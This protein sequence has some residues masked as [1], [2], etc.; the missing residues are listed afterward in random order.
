[1]QFYYPQILFG[2]F[3]LAIP[4]I[5]HLFQLRRF[6]PEP[7]TN[8][9]LL[10]KLIVSS[11][12]SS[13]LKK[14][15]SLITRLLIISCLV[16]AF[17][18]PF[19][20]NPSQKLQKKQISIFL[21]NS[22]SMSLKGDNTSLFSQAKEE[23]LEA[24]PE[25]ETYNLATHDESYKNLRSEDLK[26][27]I[28][29]IVYSPKP[30]EINSIL[31]KSESLFNSSNNETENE[32]IVLSDFQNFDSDSLNLNTNYN[33]HFVKYN[34]QKRINFSIDTVYLET[35]VDENT[36]KFTVSCSEN[37]SKSIPISLYGD[38]KLLG[39]FSL[40]F[41][42]EQSKTYNFSLQ[43]EEILKGKITIEDDGLS[44]DNE[45]FFSIKKPDPIN[46]LVISDNAAPYLDKIFNKDRFIYQQSILDKLEYEDI[47][48]A[49]LVILNEIKQI[50]SSLRIAIENY[51]ESSRLLCIIPDESIEVSNYNLLF[52]KLNLSSYNQL[53]ENTLK[54]TNIN[55]DHPIFQNVFTESIQN[56]DY[57]SFDS[58]FQS[59]NPEKA[60]AFSNNL[61]L[62]ESRGKIYRFNA[63][64]QDNSNFL[65][66]PLVVIS[67]YNMAIQAQSNQRLFLENGDIFT[68]KLKEELSQDEVLNV[69]KE[70]FSFIP[71]QDIN[72]REIKLN[73][74]DYPNSAGHYA[75]T[76]N[77]QDTL[78]ILA[79]NPSR[80]ES[81][82]E[83]LELSNIKN[84]KTY[85]DFSEYTQS[86][87]ENY[88]IQ[89][90]WKWFIV[91]AL[92][93]MIIEL[94]LLRYIK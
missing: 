84:I 78:N 19:I 20:P 64:I 76:N 1:M 62:L 30:I 41:E 11:R 12:K 71:R 29:D 54:L 25:N 24:L 56:F 35:S 55:F 44:Y 38:N 67:F 17:A 26:S 83:Y 3:A 14:W 22:Y 18:Q 9:V 72:G 32:L 77:K 91:L 16:L 21:D 90:L 61:P 37:I 53:N 63:S 73:F 2:L 4:I 42:N 6:K 69:S 23:L 66:S 43:E 58:Y 10:K 92:I 51:A 87:Y 46:V 81:A 70:D 80:K 86:F 8:V 34:P 7:F 82:L 85:S 59:T 75:V 28:Y 89:S 45:L 50:P 49:D 27:L 52:E 74:K 36:L 48:S 57:P 40:D 60:L 15:L 68:L 94:L 93:F 47:N 39:K 33:Y 13:K 65:Q 5:I 31:S 88:N 79:F